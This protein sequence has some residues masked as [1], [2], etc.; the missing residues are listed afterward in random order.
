MAAKPQILILDDS[1][2]ALDYKTDADLRKAIRENYDGATTIVIAQRISSIMSLDDIIIL[3]EGGIIGHGS[4]EQLM[5][6]CSLYR[7]I[8]RTQMGGV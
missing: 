2:S 8:Y 6:D 3:D 7:D 5:E 4:H 1:S